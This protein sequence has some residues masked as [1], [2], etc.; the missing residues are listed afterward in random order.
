MDNDAEQNMYEQAAGEV[1]QALRQEE[2]WFR[3][4]G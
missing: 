4:L 2:V 1:S 3:S